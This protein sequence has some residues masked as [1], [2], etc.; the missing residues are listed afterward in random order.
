MQEIQILANA[1][2]G[3]VAT[4]YLPHSVTP[5]LDGFRPGLGVPPDHQRK[6]DPV[7]LDDAHSTV[8]LELHV[9]DMRNDEGS[10][11]GLPFAARLRVAVRW[12]GPGPGWTYQFPPT[13]GIV[14]VRSPLLQ[15]AGGSLEASWWFARDVH[16]S[17]TLIKNVRFTWGLRAFALP[18]VA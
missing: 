4:V 17:S 6:S 18:E 15:V 5:M 11:L 12:N 14:P 7:A 3:N 10:E 16:P 1:D 8:Q 2:H 9:T 13:D